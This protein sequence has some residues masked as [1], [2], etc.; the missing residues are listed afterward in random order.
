MY[1][2]GLVGERE[3]APDEEEESPSL[4][5]KREGTWKYSKE[6]RCSAT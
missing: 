4:P 6:N 2:Q 5:I 1:P 3:D